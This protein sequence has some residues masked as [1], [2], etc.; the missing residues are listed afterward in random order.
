MIPTDY[1]EGVVATDWQAMGQ[2]HDQPD[3]SL[4]QNWSNYPAHSPPLSV[5][6]YQGELRAMMQDTAGKQFII[7][8]QKII[9][10]QWYRIDFYVYWKDDQTAFQAV[11]LN[12]TPITPYNGTDYKYYRPNVYNHAGNYFKF[13]LYRSKNIQATNSLYYG[14]IKIWTYSEPGTMP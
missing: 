10:G 11:Y 8:R 6:Y 5:L 14:D 1:V 4:G 13:G 12:N 3:P 9:K 2:W 7:G